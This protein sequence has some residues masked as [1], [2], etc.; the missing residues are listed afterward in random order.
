MA[1]SRQKIDASQVE[2]LALIGSTPS[3]MAILLDCSEDV[4]DRRFVKAI[5]RG[6]VRRNIFLRRLQFDRAMKGN[7]A[8]LNWFLAQTD[9]QLKDLDRRQE[10][11]LASLSREELISRLTEV[12][13]NANRALE[14]FAAKKSAVPA[15]RCIDADTGCASTKL[16]N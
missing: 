13:D 3:E 9:E 12:R 15:E 5:K 14:R 6:I 1:K 11:A 8:A 10:Q 2:E 16:P 7:A 4:L